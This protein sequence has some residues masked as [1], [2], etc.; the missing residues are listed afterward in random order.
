MAVILRPVREN[1][2][3]SMYGMLSDPESRQM[4]PFVALEFTDRATFNERMAEL[5][6][7]PSVMLYAVVA[8]GHF[9][10]ACMS[11]DTELGREIFYWIRRLAWGRGIS[12]EGLAQLLKIDHTRP[13]Y[14][15][16]T[17][18]NERALAVLSKLAFEE[19][20]RRSHEVTPGG[21]SLTE[22]VLV[23]K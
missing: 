6:A 8:G 13:I 21:P 22:I 9:V 18:Q 7:D 16:V 20:S 14:A 17:D 11:F 2:M 12:T 5:Q 4:A 3:D 15:R 23:K 1:D 19:V 10:G